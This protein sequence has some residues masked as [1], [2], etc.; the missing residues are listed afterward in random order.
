MPD[1]YYLILT[2]AELEDIEQP[3]ASFALWKEDSSVSFRYCAAHRCLTH[4]VLP[5]ERAILP[6][7]HIDS[8]EKAKPAKAGG[9]KL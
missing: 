1:T 3:F 8:N 2:E 4:F 6:I 5:P 7:A 9:A